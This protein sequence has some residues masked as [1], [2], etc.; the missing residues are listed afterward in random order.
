[1]FHVRN[2][3]RGG[4]LAGYQIYREYLNWSVILFPHARS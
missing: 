1:M 3:T 2:I 4:L